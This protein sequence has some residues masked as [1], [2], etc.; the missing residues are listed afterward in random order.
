MGF[1]MSIIRYMNSESSNMEIYYLYVYFRDKNKKTQFYLKI[2]IYKD[3]IKNKILLE[4]LL[5]D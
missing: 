4:M 1:I 5:K 2:S 3:R